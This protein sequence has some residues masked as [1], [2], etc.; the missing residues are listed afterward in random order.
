MQ[1]AESKQA[2]P[3]FLFHRYNI[4]NWKGHFFFSEYIYPFQLIQSYSVLLYFGTFA[5]KYLL[6]KYDLPKLELKGTVEYH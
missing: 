3:M 2:M 4:W 1:K 5:E 6:C